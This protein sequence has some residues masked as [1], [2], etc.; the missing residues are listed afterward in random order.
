MQMWFAGSA[1]LQAISSSKRKESEGPQ[2]STLVSKA[3]KEN[4]HFPSLLLYFAKSICAQNLALLFLAS[5]LS[6]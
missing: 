5:S 6:Y 3:S 4:K 1:A 2:G